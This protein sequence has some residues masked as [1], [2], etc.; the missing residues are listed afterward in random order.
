MDHRQ[1]KLQDVQREMSF[2]IACEANTPSSGAPHDR[3]YAQLRRHFDAQRN[4]ID[5]RLFKS[6]TRVQ[7]YE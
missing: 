7:P 5:S 3:I 6:L 1:Q 2:R 4:V